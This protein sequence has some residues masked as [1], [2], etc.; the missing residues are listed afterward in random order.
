MKK[1]KKRCNYEKKTGCPWGR[2]IKGTQRERGG[3]KLAGAS[4][5]WNSI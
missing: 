3:G 1:K 2:Q 5:R 4:I